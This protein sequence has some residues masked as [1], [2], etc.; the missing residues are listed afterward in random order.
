VKEEITEMFSERER[1]M[2]FP[3]QLKKYLWAN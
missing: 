2:M 3:L 1:K